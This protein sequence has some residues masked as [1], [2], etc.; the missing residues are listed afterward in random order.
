MAA[1][2]AAPHVRPPTAVRAFGSN[3][4]LAL[5]G[6]VEVVLVGRGIGFGVKPGAVVDAAVVEQRFVPDGSQR[7]D[8]IADL[9]Q[10]A[11]IE[12][13]AVARAIVELAATELG[14]RVRPGFV[15]AVLDHLTFAV[16][17]AEAGTRVDIPLRY[18]VAQLYPA[19]SAFGR[20]AV[21]L[22]ADRLGV[23]LQD[24]EWV[25]FALHCV[26][27]QWSSQDIGRTMLMTETI[28]GILRA[29]EER[30]GRTISDEER[31]AAR[32]VAHLRYLFTRVA[33]DA[34]TTSSQLALLGTVERAYPEVVPAAH[35]VARRIAAALGRD[36][37][38]GEVAYVALHLGRLREATA[39]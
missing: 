13:V 15:L 31:D 3:V 37:S 12:H 25:A 10:D 17:R 6:D 23:R 8:A 38:Q 34:Q 30:W 4:V 7:A 14:I 22:V 26:N 20:R 19:E 35:D 16:R 27:Q 24:E 32:F 29:L 18:E 1:D 28:Q 33:D 21:A 39:S 2:A 5:D 9:V 36:L 11:P